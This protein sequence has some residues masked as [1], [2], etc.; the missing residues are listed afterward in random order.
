MQGTFDRDFVDRMAR[1]AAKAFLEDGITLDDAVIAIAQEHDLNHEQ[2]KRICEASNLRTKDKLGK[3]LKD[4]DL[5]SSEVVIEFLQPPKSPGAEEQESEEGNKEAAMRKKVANESIS[6]AV[7]AAMADEETMLKFAE[8]FSS[9][10][11]TIREKIA[12]QQGSAV[13]KVYDG[14]KAALQKNASEQAKMRSQTEEMACKILDILKKEGEAKG[15]INGSL[16]SMLKLAGD[17][18]V[19]KIRIYAIYKMA[20]ERLQAMW[21]RPIASLGLEKVAGTPDANAR[22]PRLFK[23]YLEFRK[24]AAIKKLVGEKLEAQFAQI[25]GKLA[26]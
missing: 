1:S 25:V 18:Q 5:A 7:Q 9:D 3:P 15:S 17:D 8:Y 12:R 14:L 2:I 21:S 26:R 22:L 19:A 6:G 23:Q 16:S 11:S 4:F 24:E 20:D 13:R 10:S